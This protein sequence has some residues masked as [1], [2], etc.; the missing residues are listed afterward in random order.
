M[1]ALLLLALVQTPAGVLP[2]GADGKPLNLDFEAGDL[3]DW[4]AEGDAFQGQPVRGDTVFT[5]RG[6]MRSLHQGKFWVGGFETHGDK[7]TGTLTSAAFTVTHPWASYLVAGGAHEKETCVELLDEAGAVLHRASGAESETLKRVAVDLSAHRGKSVRVR[8]VDRHA[9]HWGHL[10]FD[11]FRFH[12]AKPDVAERGPAR[13]DDYRFAGQAPEDAAT[14]MTVPPGFRVSLFAGE[15]DL[16]QPVGFCFDDRGRLWVAEAYCYPKRKPFPGPLLPEAERTNG[17]KILIFEDTDGDGKFDKKTVF[18]EGLNLVSGLEYGFGGLY[19]GAAPYLL[20]I[21][22]DASGD[23]PAG[24]PQ[25]LLDG[26]GLEDTHETLNSFVWGPDGWLYGCH[27]VFTHSK[28]GKPGTPDKDRTPINAGVWR[29]HPTRHQFEVFAHGTSNP[30]GLDYN[31]VGDFFV[32]AC[33]IPH[34]WHIVPGGRYQRQG[35]QHFNPYTYDDIK[36]IAKH[37]HY[38]GNQWNDGD[39]AKSGDLGGGHAHSGLVC[40]QG[41]AWPAEYHGKLFMGNVHGHRINVDAVTPK[42]SSYEGDRNPDFLLSHDKHCLIVSIQAGPDGNLFFCDW[43]DKQVC[44]RNEVEVWDRTNGRIFKVSHKDSKP[45]VG[46][47]LAKKT[48]AE[49]VA[50]Q[51]SGNEWLVRHARRVLQERGKASAETTAGVERLLKSTDAAARLRGL[52]LGHVVGLWPEGLGIVL[53][54]VGDHG[55]VAQDESEHIRAWG[56]RLGMTANLA[57]AAADPSPVVR[58]EVAS[59]LLARPLDERLKPLE[60]LLARAADAT[61]P[62][63]PHLLW[64]AG[65]PF[66]AGGADLVLAPVL[67]LAAQSQLPDFLPKM[68]RRVGANSGPAAL[69]ALTAGLLEAMTAAHQLA[70]LRGLEEAVKGKRRAEPPAGWAAAAAKLTNAPAEVRQIVRGLALKFGDPAAAAELRRVLADP[71]SPSRTAA[72]AALLDVRDPQLPATLQKLL[73]DPAVRGP[74][75]RALAAFDDPATPAAVLAA[76]P[77]LS[78][79]E[80]R[81][82]VAALASRPAFAKALLA[83]VA[84]KAVPST[85]IPAETVRQLRNL[86]DPAVTEQLAAAWGTVRETPADRKALIAATAKRLSP[87]ALARADLGAGRAVFAKVCQQC[88][89]LY[90]VGGSVGPEITGANRADL[91]YL[92]ENILDPSAVIPKEYAATRLTLADGRV[93]TGIVKEQTA[94][95]LLVATANETLT[96]PVQDVEGRAASDLSMMPDNL[97]DGLPPAQV[98]DLFAYLKH[99]QQVPLLATP[100][101][102]KDLFNGRDLAGWSG[103]PAVWS[104]EGGEIVGRT[105]TGLKGNAFLVSGLDLLDFK[106]TLEVRLTP[107][108]ANSG[109][110]FRSRPVDGGEMK[111]PQA[112]I[113]KGWWGK[114]YEENGRG[115]LEKAGGEQWVKPGKWN[116]YVIEAVGGDV[117]LTLNGHQVADRKGDAELARRGQLGFQVH[118]GG[119]TEVR[120]RNL[121]L[122][123]K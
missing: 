31:A 67:A 54:G 74:A 94:A 36:T 29:Y 10:N 57:T 59:R 14:N 97:L 91:G 18:I 19:V 120:F 35:G 16:H 48:D 43:S 32:E 114:L 55:R 101:T 73:A 99:P 41:G 52:W 116:T 98:R 113:G 17:D 42:G 121:K 61:D 11:D 26:W 44:H 49:L 122:E 109:V 119:P 112:D 56:V 86:N 106:L 40:Y 30:W 117:R 93:V 45:V 15:P 50:L 70:Y 63:L 88:H 90:G 76:Y 71:A 105:S 13:A 95:T 47:D 24:P 23:K 69:S 5:R 51:T 46:L 100:E 102:A 111:G 6:D 87:D 9:G 110:Q 68:A 25:V 1:T 84:A 118:S 78:P 64:Y 22:I 107:D 66:G 81:D 58:R 89:T 28:V 53:I 96:L 72:L 82:A 4:T 34:L 2:V 85:D 65:E 62:V 83:A 92:L 37:R 103:D 115:L 75:V 123:V 20:H 104:V 108:A 80:K 3:R 21:P 79:A 38:V 60:K 39:R 8:L 33:V 27:G 12:A 77:K 7:P